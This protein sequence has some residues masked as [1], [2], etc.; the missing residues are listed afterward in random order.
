MPT[1]EFKKALAELAPC[2]RCGQPAA[3]T[4][5]KGYPFCSNSN[6]VLFNHKMPA[7]TWN[8]LAECSNVIQLP[9]SH[10]ANLQRVVD[11]MLYVWHNRQDTTA[12]NVLEDIISNYEHGRPE[13]HSAS[14]LE[15]AAF[16]AKKYQDEIDELKK[17]N[18][19]LERNSITLDGKVAT[20]AAVNALIGRVESSKKQLQNIEVWAVEDEAGYQRYYAFHRWMCD[21]WIEDNAEVYPDA[22]F[23]IICPNVNGV[24]DLYGENSSEQGEAAPQSTSVEEE[25]WKMVREAQSAAEYGLKKVASEDE[26]SRAQLRVMSAL[27]SLLVHTLTQNDPKV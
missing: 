16:K 5:T 22:T 7:S 13:N 21:K 12:L 9:A 18:R 26:R 19:R 25:I 20:Q 3:L 15:H 24:P 17:E 4:S 11:A 2:H 10:N 1:D 27:L 14:L 23:G 6:C 8:L